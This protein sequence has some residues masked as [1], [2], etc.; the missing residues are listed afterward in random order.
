MYAT[1]NAYL[2]EPGGEWAVAEVIGHDRPPGARHARSRLV[3]RSVDVTH[4]ARP[5]RANVPPGG[6]GG[7]PGRGQGRGGRPDLAGGQAA[8]RHWAPWHWT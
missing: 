4:A 5:V 2:V 7:A 6:A 3:S 1:T 8:V